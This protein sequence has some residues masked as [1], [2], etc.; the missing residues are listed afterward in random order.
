METHKQTPILIERLRTSEIDNLK[1]FSDT[2]PLTF[3]KVFKELNQK[4]YWTDITYETAC[5][6]CTNLTINKK[7]IPLTSFYKFFK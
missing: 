7:Y 3:E 4:T 1:E 6:I 2:L 5:I